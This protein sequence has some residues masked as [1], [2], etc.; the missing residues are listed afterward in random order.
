MLLGLLGGVGVV[1]VGLVATGNLSVRRHVVWCD[2]FSPKVI[3]VGV[4]IRICW[5]LLS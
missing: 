3:K 2:G 4:L 1:E 5:E